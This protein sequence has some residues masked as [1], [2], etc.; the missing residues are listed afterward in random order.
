MKTNMF[1]EQT[2]ETHEDWS[3][4]T[5]L[6]EIGEAGAYAVVQHNGEKGKKA[7]FY[8]EILEN[9]EGETLCTTCEFPT[10][11]KLIAFI[12]AGAPDLSD[13]QES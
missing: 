12:K 5:K 1:G 8:A 6:Q 3:N 2:V 4:A 11:A 10:K 9:A 13:I 7:G